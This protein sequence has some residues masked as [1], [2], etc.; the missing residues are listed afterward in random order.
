MHEC[1]YLSLSRPEHCRPELP[2]CQGGLHIFINLAELLLGPGWAGWWRIDNN[3]LTAGT[4]PL[5]RRFCFRPLRQPKQHSLFL[6]PRQFCHGTLNSTTH[7]FLRHQQMADSYFYCRIAIGW[8]TD[9]MLRRYIATFSHWKQL[10]LCA[11]YS[12]MLIGIKHLIIRPKRERPDT[13]N[14]NHI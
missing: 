9:K 1:E 6:N 11:D 13:L 7:L 8:V 10:S 3:Y 12:G 2:K 14:I 5:H 4:A